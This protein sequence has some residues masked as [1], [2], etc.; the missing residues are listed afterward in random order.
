MLFFFQEISRT[1]QL[2]DEMGKQLPAIKVFELAIAFLKDDLLKECE[3]KVA[4]VIEDNDVYWVLT[5]PS[6]WTATAKQFMRE[7][8]LK[9][10]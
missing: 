8:A 5:V 9:V 6:I 1:I 2:E 3:K 4:D 7:A 10:N